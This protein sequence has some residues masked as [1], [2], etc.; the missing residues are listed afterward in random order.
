VLTGIDRL[1]TAPAGLDLIPHIVHAGA[2]LR[3]VVERSHH[4]M[5]AFPPLRVI[6]VVPD[7]EALDVVVPRINCCHNPRVTPRRPASSSPNPGL[8]RALQGHQR[9]D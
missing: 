6:A 9:R 2:E 8:A 3:L 5:P 7:D 1:T 4:Q